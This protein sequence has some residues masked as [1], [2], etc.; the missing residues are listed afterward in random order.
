MSGNNKIDS[1]NRHSPMTKFKYLASF[2]TDQCADNP[3]GQNEQ[4]KGT[5]LDGI[6]SFSCECPDGFTGDRCETDVD[7]CDSDPCENDATCTDKINTFVCNCTAGFIGK[8]CETNVDDCQGIICENGGTCID[9]INGY[10]CQCGCEFSGRHC[11]N[12]ISK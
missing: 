1:Y 11:E 8:T 7:E 4:N 5:C 12:E 3:C 9:G 6:N 10:T 2:F